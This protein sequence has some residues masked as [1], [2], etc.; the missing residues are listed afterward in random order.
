MRI[1][2]WVSRGA[3]PSTTM[4]VIGARVVVVVGPAVAVVV[5]AKPETANVAPAVKLWYA[6]ANST[7]PGVL[8]GEVKRAT[9]VLLISL[10]ISS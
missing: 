8:I 4:V 3:L 1:R 7:S 10:M 9:S 2:V 6:T 5:V